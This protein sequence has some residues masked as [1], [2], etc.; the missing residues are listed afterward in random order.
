MNISLNKQ[1]KLKISETLR[2]P[3]PGRMLKKAPCKAFSK[4]FSL[5]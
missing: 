1:K 3:L 4:L 2:K 5:D